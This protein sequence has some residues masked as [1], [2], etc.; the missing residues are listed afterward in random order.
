NVVETTDPATMTVHAI[1]ADGTGQ[2]T[3]AT[4]AA[5]PRWLPDGRTISFVGDEGTYTVSADGGAPSL[6]IPD[7]FEAVWSPDGTR[8][9]FVRHHR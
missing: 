7:S 1:N 4:S 8:I 5:Y 6:L 2:I 9:A 3:L